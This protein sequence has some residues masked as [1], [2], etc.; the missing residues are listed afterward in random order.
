MFQNQTTQVNTMM[1]NKTG[2]RWVTRLIGIYRKI[3][4]G[5]LKT[6][7]YDKNQIEAEW[8]GIKSCLTNVRIKEG[9]ILCSFMEAFQT[10]VWLCR[11]GSLIRKT[12][13]C[14]D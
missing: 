8:E 12:Q 7:R 6:T 2:N 13:G 4:Y 11:A 9:R 10:D 5:R 14:L 1:I 3:Q